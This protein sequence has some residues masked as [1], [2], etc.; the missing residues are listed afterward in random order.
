MN[1]TVIA[2]VSIACIFGGTLV[3]LAIRRILPAD[4]LSE[5]SRDAVKVGAGMVSMMAALVLGLLVSSAKQHFDS[6][7]TAIVEGGARII[8]LDRLLANYG[9]ESKELREDLRQGVAS[10]IQLLWPEEPRQESLRTFEKATMIEVLAQRIRELEPQNEAQRALQQQA[11]NICSEL[12]LSRWL[13][14]EQ[15]QTSLPIQFIVIL[16]FWLTMLY[17]SFGLL[18]PR[19]PTVIT[20]MFVGA[21]SLATALFLILE[22]NRPMDGSIKASSAPMHKALEHLGH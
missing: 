4:H 1:S 17:M 8:L 7:N 5:E 12:M 10:T 13:Q 2:L 3:G 15:A 20:A 14:I 6:T 11:V 9:A 18:A 19:N 22:M 21:L 16:L